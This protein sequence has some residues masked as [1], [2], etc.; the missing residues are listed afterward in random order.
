MKWSNILLV[1]GMV[2]LIA[3]AVMSILK[4]QPYSDYVL[5]AGAIIIIFRGAVRQREKH[6]D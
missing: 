3:G 2:V 6:N 1:I 5:V 4:L